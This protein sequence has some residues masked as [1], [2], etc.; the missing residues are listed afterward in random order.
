MSTTNLVA[1]LKKLMSPERK[2]RL[3]KLIDYEATWREIRKWFRLPEFI[4][5]VMRH[6]P[7]AMD[8]NTWGNLTENW[9]YAEDGIQDF[10]G[11]SPSPTRVSLFMHAF[12][13]ATFSAWE[14]VKPQDIKRW[15]LKYKTKHNAKPES[16]ATIYNQMSKVEWVQLYLFVQWFVVVVRQVKKKENQTR[17]L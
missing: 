13:T 17:L 15:N 9:S 7:S 11:Q 8:Q 16:F 4:D 3:Y 14:L 1:R 6:F 5:G 12:A 2:D 10:V